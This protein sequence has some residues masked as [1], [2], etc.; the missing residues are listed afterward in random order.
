VQRLDESLRRRRFRKGWCFV[1]PPALPDQFQLFNQPEFEAPVRPKFRWHKFL[2]FFKIYWWLPL[3]TLVLALVLALVDVWFM[4]P[5]YT[6]QAS[7]WETV[8][9]QLPE[10]SIF[11]EDMETFVGT[12]TDV[13][14]SSRIR[15]LVLT[16]LES[17]G[18]NIP[19][20]KDGQPL[21]VNIRL[22]QG[23]KSAVFVLEATG[24]D[25]A[26]TKAYLDTLMDAYL[27]LKR[28]VREVVSG[29]TL[30]SITEQ[31]QKTDRD[32]KN[33]QE[34]L[35]TF[36]R[37]NNLTVLQEQGASAG[38]YL[39]K[40]QTELSDLELQERL[41]SAAMQDESAAGASTNG[42]A[43]ILLSKL[44]QTGADS[45]SDINSAYASSFQSI[46]T[47]KIERQKL[48]RYLRPK[49]PK[50]VKLDEEI[51]RTQRLLDVYIQESHDELAAERETLR[52]KIDNVTSSIKEWED[53]VTQ[54]NAL[55]AEADQ[56]K[57]NVQRVQDV[58]DRLMLLVQNVDISRNIDQETLAVLEPASAAERSYTKVKSTLQTA[59]IA[60]LGLGVGLILLLTLRDDRFNSVVEFNERLGDSVI[61]QVPE[62]LHTDG[63]SPQLLGQGENQ[64]M[65]AESY[66]NLRSALLF[67]AVEG[68]RPKVVLIT[69][70]LPNEGK[71]TVAANLAQALAL[72]GSRVI[73][74]DCDLRKGVIHERMGLQREPGLTEILHGSASLEQAIQ[75]NSV[76]NLA[77]ISRGK[78]SDDSGDLFLGSLFAKV[79]AQ[80]REQFDYVL[81]DSSPVLATDDATTLAPTMDGTLFVVRGNFTGG[82]QVGEALE[83]LHQRQAKILGVV[84]NRAN[85]SASSY[86]YYKYKEYHPANIG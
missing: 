60:G 50:I 85:A 9:L 23:N 24:S 49:H 74:V 14:Q 73:L 41:L 22:T 37:T 36:E 16:R 83:L 86:H 59:A 80:L 64:Y 1:T 62:V 55:I 68:A 43:L 4:P 12:Q 53:K 20:G 67:M 51:D 25:P 82:R 33:E 46:E 58:Y 7:M 13:L 71:S 3:V 72:S 18:I 26:F 11:S 48:S 70:A 17:Q 79:I 39:M 76:A 65:L 78:T 77:F 44:S 47:L 2:G 28:N 6:S 61:G 32:L 69:S 10:G 45:A 84:F 42:D 52:L 57:L 34:T 81:I 29:E 38:E 66:R 8:K 15:E 30:A 35:T 54:A 5:S 27:E 63:K 75:R 19:V 40:L 21:P 31:V 56:L